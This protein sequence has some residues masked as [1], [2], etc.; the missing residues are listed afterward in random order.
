MQGDYDQPPHNVEPVKEAAA[1]HRLA[2]LKGK[3]WALTLDEAEKYYELAEFTNP[4][5]PQEREELTKIRMHLE[6][7][8][9]KLTRREVF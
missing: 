2:R 4:V 9:D 3:I 7:R 6:R 8:I 1:L 5:G